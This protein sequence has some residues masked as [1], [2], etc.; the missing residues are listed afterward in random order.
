[1]AAAIR[2]IRL[3]YK[4]VS[5]PCAVGLDQPRRRM[6]KMDRQDILAGPCDL[7]EK[8]SPRPRGLRRIPVEDRRPIGLTTLQGVMHEVADHDR[9]LSARADIDAAMAG[10]MAGRQHEPK[11]IVELIAVVDEQRLAGFD[12]RLA[13]VAKHIAA[14]AARVSPRLV[15]SSQAAYS[16][17]WKIYLAF[18]NVGTH[19][20][21]RSTV[22][23]PQWSICRCVQ[24]T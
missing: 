10:R 21:S 19:R 22:F 16:P 17:L 12:D 20:P 5:E 8:F 1:M 3:S 15:D 24:Y 6:W 14:A 2:G 23:Q 13:I 9:V 18:G 11:R 4:L 7:G